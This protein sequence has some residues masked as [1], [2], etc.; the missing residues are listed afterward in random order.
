MKTA[1]FDLEKALA[2]HPVVTRDG[3]RVADFVV[4]DDPDY[5]VFCYI[6]YYTKEGYFLKSKRENTRDLFLLLEDDASEKAA[7]PTIPQTFD[8]RF[9][10]VSLAEDLTKRGITVETLRIAQ[11]VLA[12]AESK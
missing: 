1:P 12:E 4:N 10:A 5:P 7:S 2:G 9:C 8:W 11:L 3:M 6:G